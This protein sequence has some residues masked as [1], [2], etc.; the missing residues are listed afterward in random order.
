MAAI[1]TAGLRKEY[2]SVTALH[3]LDL[4]VEAGEAFGF[5]GPNGAG[6]STTIDLL[7][8][9]ATPTA[10]SAEVLGRDVTAA[11][12]DCRRGVGVLPEGYS[13]F[14]GLTARE[15]LRSICR[16][17]GVEDDPDRLC[18]AVGLDDADR[19]RPAGGFSK[20]MRQRLV[21]ATALAGEP[22]L[23]VLDE[24]SAGLDPTGISTLREIVRTAVNDGTAV[25]FSSHHLAEVEA[26]CDRVGIMNDGRLAAVDTVEGLRERT[27]GAE[28]LRIELRREPGER[29]LGRLRGV[30]G[31]VGVSVDGREVTVG[32]RA[33]P[34]KAEAVA[35]AVETATVEDFA[36]SGRSLDQ[37]FEH[38]TGDDSAGTGTEEWSAKP[39]PVAGV[40]SS[41]GGAE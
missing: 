34:T 39:E 10:G 28:R 18:D 38:Y 40:A 14:E 6:K 32:C 11:G 21:L 24:P 22:D 5:L 4:T 36:V 31:V 29:V 2:G 8:G 13:V 35:A 37:L 25:F 30:E 7:L 23:L 26:V 41:G 19:D 3:D 1:R 15:H 33:P 12:G 9:F 20:G 16:L 27:G 17:K